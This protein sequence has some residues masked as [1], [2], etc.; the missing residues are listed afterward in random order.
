MKLNNDDFD[1]EMLFKIKKRFCFQYLEDVFPIELYYEEETLNLM[2]SN[3][4]T[5]LFKINYEYENKEE[6]LFDFL[7]QIGFG[8]K[9]FEKELANYIIYQNHLK[10]EELYELHCKYEPMFKDHIKSLLPKEL[11]FLLYYVFFTYIILTNTDEEHFFEAVK[12]F[13]YLDK[14]SLSI[15]FKIAD[16]NQVDYYYQL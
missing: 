3:F 7:K 10:Y 8:Y 15:Y 11:H 5:N 1:K 16:K 2:I 4:F 12:E 13:V 14:G 6:I 9:K